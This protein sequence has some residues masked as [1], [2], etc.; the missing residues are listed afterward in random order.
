MKGK[1]A[2]INILSVYPEL[3]S[4]WIADEENSKI[5]G[6]GYTYFNDVTIQQLKN[7]SQNN[8]FKE[9]NLTNLTPAFDCACTS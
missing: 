8:L 1:N 5:L 3:A 4:E 9:Q 2:I 6:K 7:I